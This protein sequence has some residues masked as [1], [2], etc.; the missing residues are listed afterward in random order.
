VSG[1]Y[2]VLSPGNP[3]RRIRQN[4]RIMRPT[5]ENIRDTLKAHGLRTTPQRQAILKSFEQDTGEHLS[6]EE[7]HS[8]ASRTLTTLSR[9]TVY[10]TLAELTDLGL[11]SAVGIP[12]PVRYETNTERHDHFRCRVC[13][14]LFDL[15]S[16]SARPP[17]AGP[18]RF[19]IERV[20]LRAEGICA[21][22]VDYEAGLEE[23]V[24]A[25]NRGTRG[26]PWKDVLEWAEV[27]CASTDG[28]LGTILL[29]ASPAGIL[30]L[31]FEDHFDAK[32]L[33]TRAASRRGSRTAQQHLRTASAEL[34]AF[35]AGELQEIDCAIDPT[36]LS[37]ARE[38]LDAT[39]AIPYAGH[40]SYIKLIGDLAPRDLGRW[41]GANPIP[42][43]LPCHRVT[44]GKEIPD[45]FV[46]GLQRRQWLE[47]HEREYVPLLSR[48]GSVQATE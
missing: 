31:A 46:G 7:I 30:R 27:A 10:A 22:C 14:R 36:V 33:R 1:Y 23:G 19:V 15:L 25:I 34:G 16:D 32:E 6:A 48:M 47:D 42:V 43:I 21:D 20:D 24:R 12:E 35:L 4:E 44:R 13:L 38:S 28:P 2:P 29:A 3:S 17:R 41:M 9:A 26:R 37:P 5:D 11:L 18:P 39:R 45:C 40:N 8:R